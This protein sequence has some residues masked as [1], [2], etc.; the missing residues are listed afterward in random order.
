LRLQAGLNSPA[1]NPPPTLPPSLIAAFAAS[2]ATG[3]DNGT[4]LTATN[5][6]N[7]EAATPNGPSNTTA[8]NTTQQQQQQLVQSELLS[9]S[10]KPDYLV[11]LKVVMGISS[12]FITN[13]VKPG[14]T[15]G[16]EL[17]GTEVLRWAY[18][19]SQCATHAACHV[20]ARYL[21]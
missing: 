8:G 18:S 2:N 11:P 5:A 12:S 15:I 16:R 19:L 14:S 7:A 10:L 3:F 1:P 17:T 6:S 20:S 4:L 21:C 13:T 9:L